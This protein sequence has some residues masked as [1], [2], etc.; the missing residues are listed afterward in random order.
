MKMRLPPNLV[1]NSLT[2]H[3]W[4]GVLTGA[5]IYLICLSGTLAVFYQYFERWEQPAI[6][7][8]ERMSPAAMDR[9]YNN[10]LEEHPELGGDLLLMLPQGA[11][12]RGYIVSP[13]GS[14]FLEADGNRAAELDLTWSDMLSNLHVYLHLPTSFGMIVV[15]AL[16]ALLCGLILSGVLSHP[17]IIR[18]AFNLRL[19]G[20]PR[21]E[22]ADI[23]NRL[24]VWG[25]PF[26]L[27][28]AVTGAYFG[29]AAVMNAIF[30][31]AFFNG[32]EQAVIEAIHSPPPQLE[33]NVEPVA[34]ETA[35]EQL[36]DI[37]PET[38]PLY[39]TIENHGEPDQYMLLGAIHPQRLIYVE[40][41]RFDQQGNYLSKAGYTD[42]PPGRQVIFSFFRLHFGI[43]DGLP[44]ML[45]YGIFGLALSVVSVTGINV[46]L[47]RRKRRDYLNNLWQGLVWGTPPALLLTAI[48]S[49]IF[50]LPASGFF[51][52][53]VILSMA[54]AQR[55]DNDH[56]S[57]L[58][59]QGATALLALAL[60]VLHV[61][62]YR[63]DALG[64][65][66][67]LGIN[68]SLLT[69][70][71]LFAAIIWRQRSAWPVTQGRA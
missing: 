68:I 8:Y 41:Y 57:R 1:K 10:L 60:P 11:S 51:W 2:G 63:E 43:F 55:L 61:I 59:L 7:E 70:A 52:A 45:L 31:S 36:E 33:Q 6:A 48:F 67:A 29:L 69:V 53:G 24:S 58:Y 5:L 3:S 47:A 15:S 46:W 18:D 9:A 12:P 54:L 40:Q 27:M 17:R 42:G 39:V 20:S 65:P 62:R 34:V 38:E 50:D 23:H 71:I 35:L 37:A 14:W 30:A 22:Q 66:A 32:D 13:A 21:L 19:N 28:I 49:V 44:M 16:G 4:L 56:S 64:N 26:H 25:A